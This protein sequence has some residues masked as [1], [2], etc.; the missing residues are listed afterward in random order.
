MASVD[1]H[2]FDRAPTQIMVAAFG[3]HPNSIDSNWVLAN[4]L[5]MLA[6]PQQHFCLEPVVTTS[7]MNL[8]ATACGVLT[9]TFDT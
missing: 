9:L 2:T 1:L 3:C 8:L 7:H 4:D 5:R 6:Q